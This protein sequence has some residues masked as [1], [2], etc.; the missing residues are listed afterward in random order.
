MGGEG[1]F[2]VGENAFEALQSGQVSALHSRP[3]DLGMRTCARL[4][5]K[6]R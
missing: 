3:I 6:R 1:G 4:C 5:G 2:V